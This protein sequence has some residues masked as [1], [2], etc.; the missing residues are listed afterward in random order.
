MVHVVH[1]NVPALLSNLLNFS[2]RLQELVVP[3]LGEHLDVQKLTVPHHVSASAD[4]IAVVGE[5]A[6]TDQSGGSTRRDRLHLEIYQ[7]PAFL[8]S[9]RDVGTSATSL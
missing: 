2:G 9:R 8:G 7:P 3:V 5:H 6:P 4:L 1:S